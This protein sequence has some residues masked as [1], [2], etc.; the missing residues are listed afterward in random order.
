M[1]LT[2]AQKKLAEYA[3]EIGISNISLDELI[4]SHRELRARNKRSHEEVVEEIN[5]ARKCAAE[6]T[7]RDLTERGFV[8]VE[9]LKQMTFGEISEMIENAD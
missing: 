1:E 5:K 7:A 3:N 8:S 9:R 2:E 4:A 6:Q